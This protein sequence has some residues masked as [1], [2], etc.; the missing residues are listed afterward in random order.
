MSFSIR[1][2]LNVYEGF[3]CSERE[4][5]RAVSAIFFGENMM[6]NKFGLIIAFG[7]L[8]AASSAQ[9]AAGR[10]AVQR[11]DMAQ[12]RHN[13]TFSEIG[14]DYADFKNRLNKDYG[15][16]Y[17]LDISYMPQRAAPN[18]RKTA[19]QTMIYPSFSWTSFDNGYGTGTLNFAYN[20]VRYG[21]SA[22]TRLENNIGVVTGINDYDSKSTSFDELYYSYQ[23][24]GEADWLTVALGQFP[25]YNFDGTN[26]DSNQQVN[27]INYALSQNAS[28]TYS[29]AG[30]G[31]FVQIAPNSSWSFAFGAQDA[32]NIDGV[33]IRLNDLDKKHFTSF[34]YAAYTPSISG[35]GA[36]D[37]SIL[38]YNQPGVK[39]QP[40]TTNG[41]SLNLSQN[42]GE[43]LSLFGRING[44]SGSV[45]EIRRSWVAG[46]V[47]N[48]PLD[49]NP[50]DQIGL[51]FAY[52]ELDEKAV[53]SRLNHNSEKVI[54]A[55]W[56]WGISKWATITPD[57]QFYIHPAQNPKSDYGTA[58]SL[59]ATLFF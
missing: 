47:Y 58:F 41:W 20:I 6:K 35:L 39:A 52:N 34:V 56:A 46:G 7:L 33:S 1:P 28:S 4:Y 23:L 55:Y 11:A 29:T 43:K 25:L 38:L 45:A 31:S 10:G 49:R 19:W 53:G 22:A 51:A 24:P 17:A 3:Y 50:L 27:F 57:V 54:E 32:E 9:A 12:K 13:L 8:A 14:D 37:V 2:N 44:V 26:Y 21:G 18:G 15:F 48:N 59:R 40:E 16:S 42:I 30:F 5:I 36:S